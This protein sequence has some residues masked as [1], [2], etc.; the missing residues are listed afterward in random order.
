MWYGAMHMERIE[1]S[2]TNDRKVITHRKSLLPDTYLRGTITVYTTQQCRVAICTIRV[3]PFGRRGW[4]TASLNR[5]FPVGGVSGQLG[6]T[7]EILLSFGV[8]VQIGCLR[9]RIPMSD[10]SISQLHPRPHTPLLCLPNDS[11]R[12]SNVLDTYADGFEDRHVPARFHV[13]H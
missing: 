13:F 7:Q 9:T 6:P 1:M 2:R 8:Y 3:F 4:T 11:R 10:L 5:N 12:D